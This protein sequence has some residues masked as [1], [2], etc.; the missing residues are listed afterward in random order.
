MN[1][2]A[3]LLETSRE[4]DRTLKLPSSAACTGSYDRRLAFSI[5]DGEAMTSSP[6]CTDLLH[7]THV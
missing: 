4:H 3:R 2:L 7:C 6:R 5:G 1:S